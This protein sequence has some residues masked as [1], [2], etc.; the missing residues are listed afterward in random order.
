MDAP[1]FFNEKLIAKIIALAGVFLFVAVMVKFLPPKYGAFSP[2]KKNAVLP[3]ERIREGSPDI[4]AEGALARRVKTGET[5]FAKNEQKIFAVASIVKLMTALL[6]V[7]RIGPLERV[8]IAEDAKNALKSDEKQSGIPAN[9]TMKAEDL[10]KLLIAES[11]ND[12]AYA[13]AE[14]TSA[15]LGFQRPDAQFAERISRFVS[16][17]NAERDALGLT[18]TNFTNPAGRDDLLNYSTAEDLF[19]LAKTI[20]ERAP[21]IWSASR[22][23]DGTIY[24]ENGASYRFENTNVLLKEFPAIYG[25]KTGFTD[26][27]GEA[28][29]MLYELAAGDPVAIIILKSKDRIADGRIMIQWL[30]NSFQVQ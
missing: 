23:V 9:A 10:L 18:G 12:A 2:D 17:M 7:E 1:R 16:L 5:L 13:A 19:L 21:S 30:E 15:R 29:L 27:A 25:S 24:A 11:D 20:N 26:D 6:F 3:L 14:A 28:L 22:F 8:A 4:I